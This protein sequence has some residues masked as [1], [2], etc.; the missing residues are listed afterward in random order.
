MK[1]FA[2]SDLHLRYPANRAAMERLPP[3]PDD[4]LILGGD[5]GETEEHLTF[6]LEQATRKFSQ[7]I[8]VPGNHELWT[9]P[10]SELR[11]EAKYQH[12]VNLCR[13][14]GALTPEDDYPTWPGTGQRL[15]IAPLFVLYDYSFR[16]DGVAEADAL[17]WAAQADLVCTDELLLHSDPHSS[18]ARWCE[19]RVEL[20]ERR[21]SAV[22]SDAKLVLINHFPLRQ[23]HAILPAIPR[24]SIWCGTRRTEDWHLRF[25]AQVVVYGHLHIRR[26]RWVDGVRFEE[27]SFGYPGQWR[28]DLGMES[29]LREILPGAAAS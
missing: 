28:S 8:W 18:K 2:V 1:L 3:H 13:S 24:F 11:G 21:L 6:A 15:V 5:V 29:C 7:V 12:L 27:V 4:W 16:P 9:L 14:Y 25:R 17:D 10:G 23:D 20:T 22:P 19:A 26:T